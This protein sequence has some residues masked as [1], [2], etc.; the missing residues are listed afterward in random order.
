MDN[1][2]LVGEV[3]RAIATIDDEQLPWEWYFS[4]ARAA[5]AIIRPAVIEECKDAIGNKIH[6][7]DP[8][9]YN[10]GLLDAVDV[11]DALAKPATEKETGMRDDI[12]A[13]LRGVDWNRD[14]LLNAADEIT[15]LRADLAAAREANEALRETIRMET[16]L[17]GQL[18]ADLAAANDHANYLAKLESDLIAERDAAEAELAA[19]RDHHDDCLE[20]NNLL[21]KDKAD[22][23]ADLAAAREL[24]REARE[25]TRWFSLR[26]DHVGDEAKHLAIGIDELIGRDS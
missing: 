11:I 16:E 25:F 21:Q 14:T 1:D 22:L 13:Q 2:K 7:D 8:K 17:Q 18:Q 20:M 26:E 24:L 12:V 15:R 4:E 19:E 6:V 3:A 23:R 9:D 10:Q 5:L